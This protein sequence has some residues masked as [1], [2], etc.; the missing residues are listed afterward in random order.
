MGTEQQSGSGD[1]IGRSLGRGKGEGIARSPADGRRSQVTL[2]GGE[3]AARLEQ[4]AAQQRTDLAIGS[5]E[6]IQE[7]GTRA[8]E[9]V[10]LQPE[11]IEVLGGGVRGEGQGRLPHQECEARTEH[12][13]ATTRSRRTPPRT[14]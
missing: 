6:L 2:G 8:N 7:R 4:V 13:S 10:Q 1:P 3:R 14:N 9:R 11:Q 12:G 5:R